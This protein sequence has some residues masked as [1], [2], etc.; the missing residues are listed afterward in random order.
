[1]LS[2]R[3]GFATACDGRYEATVSIAR[4][5][6]IPSELNHDTPTLAHGEAEVECKLQSIGMSPG[7]LTGPRWW[8][9]AVWMACRSSS[10]SNGFLM[11]P[12]AFSVVI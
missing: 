3:D 12:T 7:E 5:V 8:G 4:A 6:R 2:G 10:A 9:S 1:M 11:K